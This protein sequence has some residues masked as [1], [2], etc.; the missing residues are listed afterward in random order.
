MDQISILI[1]VIWAVLVAWSVVSTTMVI[2]LKRKV[3]NLERDESNMSMYCSSILKE[4]ERLRKEIIYLTE[5]LEHAFFRC[6]CCGKFLKK[7]TVFFGEFQKPYCN[8]HSK[9]S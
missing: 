1:A 3:H 2:W 9:V 4:K 5:K 6:S 7:E 8:K